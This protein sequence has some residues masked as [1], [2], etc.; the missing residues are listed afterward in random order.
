M[1]TAR[2]SIVGEPCRRLLRLLV[3]R[4]GVYR[5]FLALACGHGSGFFKWALRAISRY[6][7]QHGCEAKL[8]VR[9]HQSDFHEFRAVIDFAAEDLGEGNLACF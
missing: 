5:D 1:V 7:M 2:S 8:A 6:H 3:N 9:L 4:V